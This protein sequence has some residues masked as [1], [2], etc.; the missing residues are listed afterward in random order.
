[1]A[2]I[3]VLDDMADA[4]NLIKRIMESSGHQVF[5]FTEPDKALDFLN[6]SSVDLAILDIKLKQMSGIEVLEQIKK[7]SPVTQ[8]MMLTGHPTAETH[9]ES[10]RLG[11]SEYC[12]KPIDTHELENKVSAVLQEASRE[13]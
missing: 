12:V 2:R 7:A 8:V 3:L 4:V 1:M 5:P 6:H 10:K 11:A 9:T 13:G